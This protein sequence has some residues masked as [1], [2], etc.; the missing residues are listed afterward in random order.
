MCFKLKLSLYTK[1][2]VYIHKYSQ[3]QTFT[4]NKVCISQIN[5]S[6]PT[7][8]STALHA[9]YCV[10]QVI[11]LSLLVCYPVFMKAWLSLAY[12]GTH[13]SA[14]SP[15]LPVQRGIA[16][17]VFLHRSWH[18]APSFY[19]S[20]HFWVLH[21]MVSD[22]P[23]GQSV[24]GLQGQTNGYCIYNASYINTCKHTNKQNH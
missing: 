2:N 17:D 13:V 21:L 10:M 5:R 7:T 22:T 12:C 18:P 4:V 20:G 23:G 19:G 15:V 6:T 14:R 3:S 9:L 8:H 11:W 24:F 16:L 1:Y